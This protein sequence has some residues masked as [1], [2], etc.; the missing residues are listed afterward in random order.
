ME[1]KW[2]GHYIFGN[3][4][5]LPYF[6]E[7]VE[8]S[9]EIN[10]NEG[11]FSGLAKMPNSSISDAMDLEV[12]GYLEDLFVSFTLVAPFSFH[13]DKTEQN[14][15]QELIFE[16]ILDQKN[17]AMYGTWVL[18]SFAQIELVENEISKEGIWILK[19]QL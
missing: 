4:F 17:N 6:G 11:N 3:G 19:K 8:F 12:E 2:K 13:F 10:N 7:K 5:I 9:L 15:K 14:K 16:G 18:P 1:E